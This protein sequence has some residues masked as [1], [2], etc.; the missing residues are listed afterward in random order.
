MEAKGMQMLQKENGHKLRIGIV[1]FGKFGQFLAKTMIRQGH[2]VIAS[3]RSDYSEL[4]NNMGVTFFRDQRDLCKERPD[5]ILLCTTILAMEPTLRSLPLEELNTS[6]TLF[7]DVLSVKEFP[8]NLFLEVL[9]PE[10]Q[11]L[12]THPMFGP[13]SGNIRWAGLPFVY[14]KIRVSEEGICAQKCNDFLA[15]FESEGCKMVEMTCA[16]HDRYAAGSQFLTHTVAR[17]LGHMNLEPTPIDTK[18]YETLRHLTEAMTGHSM[19]LYNGLFLCNANAME[20][21]EKLERAFDTVK[22][23]LMGKLHGMVA[24]QLVHRVSDPLFSGSS[25]SSFK[26]NNL[27]IKEREK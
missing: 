15:I 26:E 13:E 27:K 6:S 7:V 24:N 23:E 19:D 4:C 17:I 9:P 3:S 21:M 16:D 1:G 11:I 20:Q 18:S 5:V 2:S 10:C 22:N 14:D 25:S 8:M 12:C